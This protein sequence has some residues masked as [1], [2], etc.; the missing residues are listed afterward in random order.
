MAGIVSK[1]DLA[2]SYAKIIV[3]TL[4]VQIL[5]VSISFPIGEL[6][7]AAPLYQIDA[8]H[9]WYQISVAVDLAQQGHLIGYD[10]FFAAG[11][12]GGI[13]F[14]TSARAPAAIAVLLSPCVSPALAFKLFSF[15]CAIFSPAAI[16]FAAR[17]LGMS[18][19][20][21]SVAALFALIL[22]WV[23]PIRWYHT[24]GIVAWPFVTFC[25][26]W[27]AASALAYVTG[28]TELP[29]KNSLPRVTYN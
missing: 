6:L 9:H 1:V 11:Y 18:G 22:W 29:P 5:L 20:V 2:G 19:R 12:V 17:S 14:N 26:S 4:L 13:P 27:F 21:G 15:G 25:A 8:P 28:R 23:S 16:P 3:L 10:P 7:T 24:A